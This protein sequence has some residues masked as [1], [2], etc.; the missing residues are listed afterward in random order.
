MSLEMK[1]PD[2]L[3]IRYEL[4]VDTLKQTQH[5]GTNQ[6]L[7]ADKRLRQNHA[8]LLLSVALRQKRPLTALRLAR[9][10]GLD[11]ISFL[12]ALRGYSTHSTSDQADPTEN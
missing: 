3:N 7:K 5:L 12:R 4:N 8:R 1:K 9:N 11:V 10:S 6:K 2:V